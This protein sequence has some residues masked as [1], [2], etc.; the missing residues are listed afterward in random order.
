MSF[1]QKQLNDLKSFIQI[2]KA[3]PEVL[4]HPDLLFFR[5][6]LATLG[7]TL[8]EQKE[9][10]VHEAFVHEEEKKEEKPKKVKK[11]KET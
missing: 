6:Y 5:D 9:E 7:A 10:H 8:P 2:C 1:N 4:H 3:K 11:R